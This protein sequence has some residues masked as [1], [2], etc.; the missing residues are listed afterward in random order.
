MFRTVLSGV[1]K[2]FVFAVVVLLVLSTIMFFVWSR[3]GRLESGTGTIRYV[4]IEGGFYVIIADNGGQYD[5]DNLSKEF[6]IDG[7]RVDF[8]IVGLGYTN[9]FH[10]VGIESALVVYIEKL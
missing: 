10:M 2:K 7:L 5:P 3:V 9:C 8:L 4:G 6:E 1:L